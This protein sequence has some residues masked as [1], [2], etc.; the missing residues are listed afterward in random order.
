M[1][2]PAALWVMKGKARALL[3]KRAIDPQAGVVDVDVE[4]SSCV[5]K[6]HYTWSLAHLDAR[7]ANANAF[8]LHQKKSYKL[9]AEGFAKAVALDPTW[10]IAAYNLASAHSLAGKL[11][12]AVGGHR[13]FVLWSFSSTPEG[14]DRYPETAIWIVPLEP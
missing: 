4:D 13:V 1:L 9:A 12:D 2:R 10:K 14:C 5:G 3:T 11:D 6:A 8:A 7:I